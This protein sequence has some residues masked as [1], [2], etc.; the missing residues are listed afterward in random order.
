MHQFRT[1]LAGIL[2]QL[3]LSA[4]LMAQQQGNEVYRDE[5][6]VVNALI[7]DADKADLHF[8]DVMTLDLQI[9]YDDARVRVPAPDSKFFAAAWPD[10]NGAFFKDVQS[11]QES[12]AGD[13]PVQDHHLVRFQILAC[14][15]ALPL[16]RGERN[17]KV[18]EFSL[19]YELID[20]EGVVLSE[21]T[22]VFQPQ[23]QNITVQST[24]ELGEEGE[25]QGFQT[26][27][28][29][30]AWPLPLSGNDSRYSSLGVITAGL[31][32]L[33][34][35]VFMSPFSFFKRKTEVT[36]NSDRW[37][38]VLEQ[39]RA[40]GYPDDAHQIDALRRCLV[41]YC[42][43]KLGVD[44][45]YWVKHE[46]EVS[47]HQ[48]KG[49]GEFAPFRELFHDILLSPRGQGKQLLDRLSQLIAKAR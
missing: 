6:I 49:G 23:P 13:M 15:E 11:E 26:Y 7:T 29:N 17:Y 42:T 44:P 27:F 34:G 48:Q 4:Q 5:N 20:K 41:W 8:G 36:R 46:E 43:D 12:V 30:G 19:T 32:L 38:P 33:L 3:L 40:G 21:K 9:R 31:F 22:A 1:L 37:E 28:P 2:L 39:L 45:F 47:G 18:P 25:L 10:S 14:P 16:C 24:L 35:G